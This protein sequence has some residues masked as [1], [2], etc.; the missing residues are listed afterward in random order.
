MISRATYQ[1]KHK[2]NAQ[3]ERIDGHWFPSKAEAVRYQQLKVMLDQG[4]IE[5]L[6][7]QPKYPIRINNQLICNVVPDFRYAAWSERAR[8]MELVIVEDVKGTITSIYALK[9][10]LLLASY[11]DVHFVEL[12]SNKIMKWEGLIPDVENGKGG[13]DLPWSKGAKA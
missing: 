4:H 3:G 6:E 8:R 9:K 1:R 2:Y 13:D 10:K 5:R 7:L 11:P 12:N